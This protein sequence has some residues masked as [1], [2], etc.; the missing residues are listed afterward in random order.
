MQP[1]VQGKLRAQRGL[2]AGAARGSGMK[3]MEIRGG[4]KPFYNASWATE[5]SLW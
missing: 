2:T 4:K 5:R 1:A 3:G